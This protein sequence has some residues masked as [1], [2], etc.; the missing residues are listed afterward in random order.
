MYQINS[1]EIFR[2]VIAPNTEAEI[3]LSNMM[4][5][6]FKLVCTILYHPDKNKSIHDIL[7]RDI[8]EFDEKITG[9]NIIFLSVLENNYLNS[10]YF[11]EKAL[12][13]NSLYSKFLRVNPGG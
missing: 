10:E 11:N 8:I 13:S 9:K 12:A 3:N 2:S 4:F 5:N 1:F 7:K 6:K